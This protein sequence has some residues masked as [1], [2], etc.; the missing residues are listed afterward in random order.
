MEAFH[1]RIDTFS[2]V[3]LRGEVL[4]NKIYRRDGP[5][6]ESAA[7][8]LQYVKNNKEI[9]PV[10][11]LEGVLYVHIKCSSL[12]FVLTTKADASPFFL[13][14][15][16]NRI[17]ALCK[18]FC[19]VVSE[20]AIHLNFTII[21]ELLD[22]IID[23]G[24]P[25]LMSTQALKPYIQGDAVAVRQERPNL[26]VLGIGASLYSHGA[27]NEIYVDVIERLSIL[28]SSNGSVMCN[29]IIGSLQVKSYLTGNPEMKL[30]LP[31]DLVIGKTSHVGYG[32]GV[33]LDAIQFH[34]SVVLEEFETQ[35]ALKL[36]LSEGEMTVMKYQLSGEISS[37]LPFLLYN[38]IEEN[39]EKSV[40]SIELILKCDLKP[41]VYA[42][43]VK[44]RL[45]VPNNTTN[46]S[47]SIKCDSGQ[48]TEYKSEEKAVLWKTLKVYGGTTLNAKFRMHVS[49]LSKVTHLEL[50]Q[51]SVEF[52]VADCLL[53]NLHISFLKLFDPHHHAFVPHR[54]IR[55]VTVTDSYVFRLR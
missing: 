33:R 18:D 24:V 5:G 27:R 36:H 23:G 13:L 1:P 20:E 29:D 47:P 41:A 38:N 30:G 51:I 45:P 50:S 28:I 17:K 3:S 9:V 26:A 6:K 46:V 32:C 31:G 53:S 15:L 37:A 16:L 48:S 12:F 8:F 14:E 10:L 4:V 55:N 25:Q 52:E 11:E 22:E 35:R 42:S 2:I 43:N 49:N 34:P 44:V 39:Y 7:N 40:L 19:G 21:H 54:W